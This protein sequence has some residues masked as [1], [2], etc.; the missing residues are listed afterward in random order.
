MMSSRITAS[1]RGRISSAG[2]NDDSQS[3]S[4]ER[5]HPSK[6]VE[7]VGWGLADSLPNALEVAVRHL[8]EKEL[9]ARAEAGYAALQADPEAWQEELAERAVWD[10]GAGRW[11]GG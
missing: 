3:H 10:R 11:P 5:G 6:L 1:R 7:L 4:P 2:G 8:W 9:M